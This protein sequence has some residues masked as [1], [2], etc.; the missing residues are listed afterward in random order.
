MRKD[1]LRRIDAWDTRLDEAL[2]RFRREFSACERKEKSAKTFYQAVDLNRRPAPQ[3]Q[4]QPQPQSQPAA[5]AA[6]AGAAAAAEPAS[7]PSV[8]A[9]SKKLKVCSFCGAAKERMKKCP[10]GMVLYCNEQVRTARL[11]V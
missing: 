2:A 11:L 9:Q 10:C 1:V 5:A 7:Q 6:G 3:S 8:P 4:P